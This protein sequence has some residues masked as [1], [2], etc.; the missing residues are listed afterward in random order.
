MDGKCSVA[1]SVLLLLIEKYRIIANFN[2]QLQW[3]LSP[4]CCLYVLPT[5]P[6][7]TMVFLLASS[8]PR[9]QTNK[10]KQKNT[11][12][13]FSCHNGLEARWADVTHWGRRTQGRATGG[14]GIR[15]HLC[16]Q[17][18]QRPVVAALHRESQGS[19]QCLFRLRLLP[20]QSTSPA[21]ERCLRLGNMYTFVIVLGAERTL[22]E[23]GWVS[24]RL[25]FDYTFHSS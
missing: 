23:K 1:D 20:V 5:Y 21:C 3:F 22:K 11:Y 10:K 15:T 8:P 7:S 9:K 2:R 12:S 18:P 13:C 25:F 6:L 14:L 19:L 4:T 16:Q 24:P 17:L